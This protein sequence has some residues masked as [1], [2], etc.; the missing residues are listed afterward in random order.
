MRMYEGEQEKVIIHD[1]SMLP[2]VDMILKNYTHTSYNLIPDIAA[3]ILNVEKLLLANAYPK[4][5]GRFTVRIEDTLDYTRGVYEVEYRD[6]KADVQK[7]PDTAPYDLSAPMPAFTQMV[8]GYDQY[9]AD[10]TAYMDGVILKNQA[11]DF[12]RAFPK[13]HN[14]IFEH[15]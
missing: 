9:N 11:E 8:Y 10:V 5:Y 13:R 1:A 12:F 2:E 14:G 4:E 7:L 3:R 6:G 15:F